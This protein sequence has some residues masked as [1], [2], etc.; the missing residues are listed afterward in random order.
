VHP[1]W[2]TLT[3]AA[4][5]VA[6]AMAVA[7][8]AESEPPPS[9]ATLPYG[10][11]IEAGLKPEPLEC[12]QRIRA[13]IAGAIRIRTALMTPGVATDEAAVRAAAADPG[14][15]TQSFGIPLTA[16]ELR[17]LKGNGISFEVESPIGFWVDP[18]APDRFGGLWLRNGVMNVAVVHG[19]PA[20]LA[21]ARCVERANVAYVWADVSMTE[22]TA[23]LNR[24]GADMDRWRATGIPINLIDYDE[25]TGVVNVGVTEPTPQALAALQAA[26]GPLVRLVKE[27][28]ITPA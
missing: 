15:D 5:A 2:P 17:A 14:T 11:P 13:E 22:G 24:I 10:T 3:V 26:Y 8:C 28:P 21:L 9:I 25:T 12:Q 20:T 4:I 7:G 23:V 19:D 6:L 1:G 16:A 27:G 18:G